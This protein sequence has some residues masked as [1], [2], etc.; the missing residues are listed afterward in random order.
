MKKAILPILSLILAGSACKKSSSTPDPVLEKYMS[1]TAASTW[2]YR[3]VNNVTAVTTNYTLSSTTRDSTINGR[4][5]HVFSNS[6]T[7]AGEYYFISGNDYYTFRKLGIATSST[8]MED[9][10]MKDNSPVGTSWPQTVNLSITG[11]PFPI[12]ITVTYTITEKGSSRI[13]NGVTYTD[14]IHVSGNITSSLIPAANLTTDI[15]NYFARRYG[16]IETNNK[17]AL[18]FMGVSQNVDNKTVLI[19]ADIK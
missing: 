10:Y 1:I 7:G 12:P 17:L 11:V 9:N 2:N 6:N 19:S 13:V 14:V 15:Q 3:L 5:Y 8:T 18:N 4:A 16:M